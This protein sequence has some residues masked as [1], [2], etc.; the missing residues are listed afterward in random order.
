MVA[1]IGDFLMALCILKHY[2]FWNKRAVDLGIGIINLEWRVKKMFMPVTDPLYEEFV[3]ETKMI[4]Q[5]LK[6]NLFMNYSS[7]L[8]A[9]YVKFQPACKLA[10]RFDET[11]L[12]FSNNWKL[13]EVKL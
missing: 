12:N 8:Y 5:I 7:A 2:Q 13:F 9:K 1:T 6:E 10:K 4:E 3:K 11:K